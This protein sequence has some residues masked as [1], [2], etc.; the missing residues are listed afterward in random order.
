MKKQE[1]IKTFFNNHQEMIDHV[2]SLTDE[3]FTYS[4]NGKWTAGQQFNHVYLTLLPFPKILPSK[5]F[6]L[7]KFGKI[8]RPVWS[9]DTVIE[10]YFKTS[11]QAPERFLPGQVSLEQKATLTVDIQN[12]LQTIQNLLEQYTEEELDSFVLPHPLLGNL[13]IREMFYLMTYHATH[14]LKQ[15]VENLEHLKK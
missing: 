15:V 3:Q 9:Y 7:Q 5:D 10:N 11:R 1:L 12:I 6:I 2:N 13:T 8:N 14:H 4:Y